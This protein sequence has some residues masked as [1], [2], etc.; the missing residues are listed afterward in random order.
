MFVAVMMT[1][2]ALPSSSP[3]WLTLANIIVIS[4]LGSDTKYW[5]VP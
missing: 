5:S 3:Y 2:G 1:V 4:L